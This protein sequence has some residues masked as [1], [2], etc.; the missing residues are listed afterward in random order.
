MPGPTKPNPASAESI[1]HV[2]LPR[3]FVHATTPEGVGEI[4]LSRILREP[5][6]RER[7]RA[8]RNH[9]LHFALQN[10]LQH[11]RASRARAESL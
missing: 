10:L 9:L 4:R 8:G 3:I 7:L 11:V 1:R 6:L 5:L 2:S